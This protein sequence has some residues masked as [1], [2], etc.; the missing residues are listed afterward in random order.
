MIYVGIYFC[1]PRGLRITQSDF[2]SRRRY[3]IITIQ[4]ISDNYYT[5]LYYGGNHNVLNQNNKFAVTME[6]ADVESAISDGL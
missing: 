3:A 6:I 1:T 2:A 4:Y 5:A